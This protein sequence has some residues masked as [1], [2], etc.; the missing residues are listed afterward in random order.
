MGAGLVGIA[1]SP[2]WAGQ[3]NSTEQ[4]VLV[5]MSLT[6]RDRSSA[7]VEGGLWWAG[8]E[9][10]MLALD[11]AIHPP[12]SRERAAAERR[13]SRAMARLQHV[14]AIRRK[15]AA[16][17][18]RR[19]VWEITT[20]QPHLPVDKS[21]GNPVDGLSITAQNSSSARHQC[22]AETDI[23]VRL[24]DTNVRPNRTPMSGQN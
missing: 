18:R 5:A 20:N 8:S 3:L 10:L 13:I 21:V 11:G 9:A 12:G 22:P 16:T 6:A 19:S 23:N 15:H 1:L 2:Q 7:E 24:T 14:G 4:L 17:A